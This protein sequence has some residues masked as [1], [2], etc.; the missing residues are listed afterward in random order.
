LF[1]HTVAADFG[2]AGH[3]QDLETA[4]ARGREHETSL[5]CVCVCVC[6]RVCVYERE[7]E[8]GRVT[9][10]NTF[11]NVGILL[12]THVCQYTPPHPSLFAT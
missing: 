11:E 7:R 6:V 1:L 8:R 9:L 5:A 2:D 4:A 12:L 3:L 10:E